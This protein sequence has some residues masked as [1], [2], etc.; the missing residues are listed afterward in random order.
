MAATGSTFLDD[1][2]ATERENR[3]EEDDDEQ[4]RVIRVRVVTRL[5]ARRD[6]VLLDV[7]LS[8]VHVPHPLTTC[9]CVF[10]Q[11]QPRPQARPM[12]AAGEHRDAS[13]SQQFRSRNA[14][15]PILRL[16]RSLSQ[17]RCDQ[18]GDSRAVTV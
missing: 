11:K 7:F 13:H 15:R 10:L 2:L 17:R 16:A 18:I 14:A 5:H 1:P 12:N 4:P 3:D 8:V 9:A 6:P